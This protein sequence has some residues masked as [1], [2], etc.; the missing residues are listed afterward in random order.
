MGGGATRD[1]STSMPR[2]VSTRRTRHEPIVGVEIDDAA[3][4]LVELRGAAVE[5][6]RELR[7]EVGGLGVALDGE[8]VLAGLGDAGLEVVAA[9]LDVGAL[10]GE[11]VE[12]AAQVEGNAQRQGDVGGGVTLAEVQ[13]D[14]SRGRCRPTARCPP[15]ARGT[16]RH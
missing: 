1:T 14:G 7:A 8:E 11:G 13:L 4:E 9:L 2:T 10:A 15:G 12:L 5:A 6:G 3:G 16:A